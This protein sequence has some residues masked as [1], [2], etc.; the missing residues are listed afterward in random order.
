MA[1]KKFTTQFT[2]NQSPD[3]TYGQTYGLAKMKKHWKVEDGTINEVACAIHDMMHADA[4]IAS[5]VEIID[6]HHEIPA[7]IRSVMHSLA[8][9][10]FVLGINRAVDQ[11]VTECLK[12][13]SQ[14]EVDRAVEDIL[15]LG[16][17]EGDA[18]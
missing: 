1:Q 16:H 5:A 6:H 4:G 8:A 9:A 18:V 13:L 12:Q 17:E 11:S 2:S 3:T 14:D 15:R 10:L 7:E